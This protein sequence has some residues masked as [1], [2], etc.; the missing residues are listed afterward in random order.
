[1][2]QAPDNGHW[3]EI[4][5]LTKRFGSTIAVDD[6]TLTVE[7]GDIVCLLG[8]SGCGK[9]TLLR[10]IAGLETPD[11]GSVRFAGR[12]MAGAPVHR[13]N[14]GFMFQD[15]ALFPHK[16][17]TQNVAFGLKMSGMGDDAI[18]TRVDDVLS[19]VGLAGKSKRPVDELSGGEQQRV[20]LARSLA[21]NPSLLLLDEPLGS[22]DRALRER[23]MNELRE[24]LKKVG[25]TA[26]TVTHDQQEAFAL[27]DQIV[28]MQ[29]GR[30]LQ[31][32]TPEQVYRR[33]ALPE[34]ARFLGLTNL[35]QG[36]LVQEEP[37]LVSTVVGRFEA[38]GAQVDRDTRP[39]VLIR[40]E[41]AFTFPIRNSIELV[42]MVVSCS[43]RGGH[44]QVEVEHASGARLTFQLRSNP[45]NELII[46][47]PI[48]LYL[49]PD[50]ISFLPACPQ[51]TGRHDSR[52]M[53]YKRDASG[54]TVLCY[55]G[56]LLNRTP[57]GISLAATYTGESIIMD[58]ITLD[59]GDRFIEHYFTDRW[60][61]IFEIYDRRNGLF[62]A[63]Y[64]NVSRPASITEESVSADDLELD[65]LVVPGR[66][67]IVL[68][69]DEFETIVLLP[70][71]RDAALKALFELQELAQEGRLT[72]SVESGSSVFRS[73]LIMEVR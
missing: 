6:V 33:P 67:A 16:N 2:I 5:G 49:D 40:P 37:A 63:W 10:M 72:T 41:A 62:K 34:I 39:L 29:E 44:Y 13:R 19:L 60:Y 70:D 69:R 18:Q 65:L 66:P 15:H 9:T 24:I 23:L 28:V 55:P 32:G 58:N 38:R 27:A 7:R 68:D 25:V 71:E 43:F 59:P 48:R 31:M 45:D 73:N 12:D 30:V 22:L 56:Q 57:N 3:L 35:L 54:K 8:A 20:A 46:G 1:M 26:I 11:R 42:A 51:D 4:D 36:E 47:E 52:L 21:P 17:V 53:V 14:F 64:C 61:N 50:A